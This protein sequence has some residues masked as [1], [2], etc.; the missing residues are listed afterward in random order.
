MLCGVWFRHPDL[1]RLQTV[2]TAIPT[3]PQR[4]SV[5][6][7]RH[8][9][10]A[11]VLVWLLFLTYTVQVNV[12][13]EAEVIP[14]RGVKILFLLAGSYFVASRFGAVRRM[15]KH[16][17]PYFL[18]FFALGWAS[19]VWSIEPELTSLRMLTLS[20]YVLTLL[21][22]C[23]G[24]WNPQR[25]Q[26][27]L[28]MVLLS[29]PLLSI[30]VWLID[31]SLVIEVG[32][33][34]SLRNSWKG[35]T[36][37]KNTLGQLSA[38]ATLFWM[39]AYLT[40]EAGRGMALFGLA[41]SFWA[42]L[43]S[44]SSTALLASVPTCGFLWLLLRSP[45]SMK[46]YMPYLAGGF[47]ILVVAYSMAVLQLI[48]GLEILLKPITML[49]GKDQTF[50]GRSLIWDVVKRHIAFSPIL[51]TGFGAYW[52]GPTYLLS[53]SQEVA[54]VMYIYPFQ[55]HNGYI[56]VINDLGYVGLMVLVGYMVTYMRDSLKLFRVDRHQ[57]ALYLAMFF[58]VAISNLSQSIWFSSNIEFIVMSFATLALSRSLM[59]ARRGAVAAAAPIRPA[60][61]R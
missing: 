29:I 21:G 4:P 14:E 24:A 35:V 27:V 15:L 3:S 30:M 59:E 46:R 7:R 34:I 11:S 33:D 12:M 22:F 2:S 28:R 45:P 36:G 47:A 44:R 57:G 18:A 17:N 23:L 38:F 1:I 26:R 20:A 51:G 8:A 19:I 31:P 56:D 39:H 53:P 6:D 54:R 61:L 60:W 52:A 50:S 42:V 32:D 40:R 5:K 16:L 10:I 25:F 41:V 55:A 49:T 9:R 37:Q 58:M 48:P 43:A 13:L